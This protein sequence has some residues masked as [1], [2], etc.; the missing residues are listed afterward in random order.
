MFRYHNR[1]RSTFLRAPIRMACILATALALWSVEI[2]FFRAADDQQSADQRQNANTVCKVV[3]D[4]RLEDPIRTIAK[5][6]SRRMG[7][8]VEVRITLTHRTRTRYRTR[9]CSRS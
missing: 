3:A 6:Y 7:S 8:Q 4:K 5:E 1:I 2:Q 9:S